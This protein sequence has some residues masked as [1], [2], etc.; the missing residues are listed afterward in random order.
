MANWRGT[1]PTAWATGSAE[2]GLRYSSHWTN[3]FLSYHRV[4]GSNLE[5][6]I[7]A[8]PSLVLTG[9]PVVTNG[10]IAFDGINDLAQANR[11]VDMEVP[12]SAITLALAFRPTTLTPSSSSASNLIIK[13]NNFSGSVS[14]GLLYRNW[15]NGR[16]FQAALMDTSFT[17]QTSWVTCQNNTTTDYIGILRWAAGEGLR[18]DLYVAG[19]GALEGTMM[20]TTVSN[21]IGYDSGATSDLEIGNTVGSTFDFGGVFGWSRKLADAEVVALVQDFYGPVRKS[22][23]STVDEWPKDDADYVR[24]VVP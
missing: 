8:L 21:P 10:I 20:G 23:S 24:L 7:P 18:V 17:T 3:L 11:D 15:S 5:S 12:T 6:D 4:N 2:S 9:S 16:E 22:L 13:F 1:L 14:Y 19:T